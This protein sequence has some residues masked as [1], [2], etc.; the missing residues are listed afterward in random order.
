MNV[1]LFTELVLNGCQLGVMLFLMASGLTLILGIMNFVNLTHGSFYMFGSYFTV[2]IFNVTG[3][4]MIAVPAAL[5]SVAVLAALLEVSLFRRLY[6]RDHL[7]Q[8]LCTVGLIFFF[9]EFV[10]TAWGPAP[11]H[12]EVP[13][14][15]LGSVR[16]FADVTYP[17]LRLAIIA[18][19]LLI[20]IFLYWL[21]ERTRLGMLIRAGASDR[22]MVGALGV[23]I[24]L[25]YTLVFA[26]GAALAALAGMLAGPIYA[27]QAGMGDNVLILTL[28]VIV[29]GGIGSVRGA[30]I[31]ALFVGLLDTLGRA[32]LPGSISDVGIYALMAAILYVSPQGLARLLELRD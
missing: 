27:V 26:I 12:A 32:M 20:A 29:I 22:T 24:N 30:V 9:N 7:D 17:V 11:L 14:F 4:L 28:V 19:G 31:G 8:V 23:D 21:I 6:A 13:D 3:S 18:I 2:A 10:R 16:L 25:L 1:V 15:L 5:V